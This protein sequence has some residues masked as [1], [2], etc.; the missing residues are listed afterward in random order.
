MKDHPAKYNDKFAS[1]FKKILHDCDLIL[2]PFAGTGKLKDMISMPNIVCLEIEPEWANDILGDTLFLP[3]KNKS[4]DA[5]CT[6]PTYGNR[7]ADKYIDNRPDKHYKRYTYTHTLGRELHD[8]NS[9]NLQWGSKYREF[10]ECA[11]RECVRVLKPDGIFCLNIKD[12]VRNKQRQ[13][14]TQ[15]HIDTLSKLGLTK[16]KHYKIKTGGLTHGENPQRINY[17]SIIHFVKPS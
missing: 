16:I 17:E 7:M 11:W 10:H 14:V 6:S 5:I 3:F 13:H 4:F 15:W 9:G 1:Y 12:H 2:D 8:D